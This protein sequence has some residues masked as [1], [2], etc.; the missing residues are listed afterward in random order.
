MSLTN[1]DV[2]RVGVERWVADRDTSWMSD[3]FVW[4]LTH[5][6]GWPDKAVHR[7]LEEFNAFA[8]TWFEPFEEWRQEIE[9]IEELSDGRVLA[10]LHQYGR[11]RGSNAEVEMRYAIVFTVRDEKVAVG[12]AYMPVELALVAFALES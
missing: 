11:L 3:D 10:V 8:E 2:V 5:Y 4:D 7:G 12:E 6:E 9:R 1:V